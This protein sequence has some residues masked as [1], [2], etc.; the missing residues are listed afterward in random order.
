M[1]DVLLGL[2]VIKLGDVDDDSPWRMT[3]DCWID[4]R[5]VRYQVT[6]HYNGWPEGPPE[7]TLEDLARVQLGTAEER[8]TLA[9]R[10]DELDRQAAERMRETAAWLFREQV[11]AIHGDE[12]VVLLDAHERAET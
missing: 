3:V 12:S 8:A 9:R 4:G 6:G 11:R 2:E 10:L 7:R 1:T 5:I